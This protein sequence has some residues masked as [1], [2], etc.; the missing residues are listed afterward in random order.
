MKTFAVIVAASACLVG[1]S[2]FAQAASPGPSTSP[3]VADSPETPQAPTDLT[4][5]NRKLA[6]D[7]KQARR[8][9]GAEIDTKGTERGMRQGINQMRAFCSS[10]YARC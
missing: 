2:A 6:A 5:I 8:I 9:Q 7:A 1:T 3:T 4:A 10:Q